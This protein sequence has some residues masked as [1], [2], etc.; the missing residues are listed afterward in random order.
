MPDKLLCLIVRVGDIREAQ[1]MILGSEIV[2]TTPGS[3]IDVTPTGQ[4]LGAEVSNVDVRMFDDWAFAAFMRALLRHQALLVRGQRL[5]ARELAAFGQRFGH[6]AVLYTS[7]GTVSGGHASFAS[8]YAVYDRLSPGL[9][10]RIAHL[11]IRHLTFEIGHGGGSHLLIDRSAVSGTVQ[12]L[13]SLHPDTGRSM[14]ALGRRRHAYLVGLDLAESDALL[15]EL[16]Q[17]AARPEFA[18]SHEC[19]GGDLLVWDRRCTTHQRA[20][21]GATH[22][23]LLPRAEIWSSMSPA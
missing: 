23:R 13:V 17:F 22:P 6:A 5:S 12:P 2:R 8:L 19:R 14:L 1:A 11:K 10:R 9:R 7:Y 16:W 21:A 18:W 4:A 3:L 20:P 15:D